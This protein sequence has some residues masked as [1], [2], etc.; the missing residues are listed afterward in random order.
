MNTPVPLTLKEENFF[1]QM[2]GKPA[3]LYRYCF[4][5]K[6]RITIELKQPLLLYQFFSFS[7]SSFSS[8]VLPQVP[9][10][11]ALFQNLVEGNHLH[12]CMENFLKQRRVRGKHL[13][14]AITHGITYALEIQKTNRNA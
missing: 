9:P 7:S 3:P 8:P 5:D 6:D 14:L 12:P 4:K 10:G 13:P 11:S 1:L 2:N